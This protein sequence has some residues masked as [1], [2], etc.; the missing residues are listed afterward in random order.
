[1]L[2][3]LKVK[4]LNDGSSRDNTYLKIPKGKGEAV[5]QGIDNTMAKT[6]RTQRRTVVYETP[7][8]KPNME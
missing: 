6:K 5:N 1:M 8:R 7:H 3:I 4:F 2:L